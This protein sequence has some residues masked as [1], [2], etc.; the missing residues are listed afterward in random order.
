MDNIAKKLVSLIPASNNS[1]S[2]YWKFHTKNYSNFQLDKI[3]NDYWSIKKKS[4][5]NILIYGVFNFIVFFFHLKIFFSNSY[6]IVSESCSRSNRVIDFDAFRHA[7]SI[8]KIFNQI[9]DSYPFKKICVIG[10]GKANIVGPLLCKK[11]NNLKIISVNL[12][13]ALIYDHILLTNSDLINTAEISI[14]SDDEEMKQLLED[15]KIKLILVSAQNASILKQKEIDLFI[16]IHSFQEMTMIKYLFTK[17]S[18]FYFIVCGNTIF[19]IIIA[20]HN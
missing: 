17:Y 15:D 20:I 18:N 11:I 3:L 5:K 13:E 6:S 16:N 19:R 9:K 7:I 14:A 2:S 10:D 4:F 8:D 12:P 1:K